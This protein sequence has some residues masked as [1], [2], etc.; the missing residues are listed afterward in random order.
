MPIL[1][2][3]NDPY[4][5]F[6]ENER[7][8]GKRQFSP[9]TTS[10][11]ELLHIA[12]HYFPQI[13]IIPAHLLQKPDLTPVE[14]VALTNK[15]ELSQPI[16]QKSMIA[17]GGPSAAT[18]ALQSAIAGKSALYVNNLDQPLDGKI[19]RPIWAGAGNHGEPDALTEGPA[20]LS[21]YYPFRFIFKEILRFF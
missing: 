3:H 8:Q 16:P 6:A 13:P 1:N 15:P 9:W 12:Q 18:V 2:S 4:L 5:A 17:V 19:S 7:R 10:D 20:Y 11:P 14:I 21:G